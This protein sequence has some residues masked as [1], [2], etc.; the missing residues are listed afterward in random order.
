M[1]QPLGRAVLILVVGVIAALG[2]AT[3]TTTTTTADFAITACACAETTSFFSG[4]AAA[5]GAQAFSGART[6]AGFGHHNDLLPHEEGT[7]VG[8]VP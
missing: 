6:A 8:R 3:T 7:G 4:T 2:S 1:L 5:R